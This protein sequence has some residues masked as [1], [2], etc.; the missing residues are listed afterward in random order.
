MDRYPPSSSRRPRSDSQVDPTDTSDASASVPAARPAAHLRDPPTPA[1]SD[2]PGSE[3]FGPLSSVASRP[4]LRS[5][6]SRFSLASL[7]NR[8]ASAAASLDAPGAPDPSRQPSIRIR[9]L[10]STASVASHASSAYETAPD[11]QIPD[12]RN[13]GTS[14]TGG[15]PRSLSQPGPAPPPAAYGDAGAAARARNTRRAMPQI[16]LPRLTEEGSRPTMAEL[17]MGSTSPLSPSM[18]MP[19]APAFE[20]SHSDAEAGYDEETNKRPRRRTIVGR[21]LRPGFRRS[22]VQPLATQAGPAPSD[23]YNQELVDWLDI[24]GMLDKTI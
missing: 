1:E 15:R 19:T 12:A 5:L 8:P 18:S 22:S 11:M 9:R 6:R 21:I 4:S 10:S 17:G 3:Y 14:H 13:A 20:R 24:I 7:G 16:A 2:A 23:E